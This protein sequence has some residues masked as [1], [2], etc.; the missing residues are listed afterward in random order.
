MGKGAI[1]LPLLDLENFLYA[2]GN[3][4]CN[5]IIDGAD[6]AGVKKSFLYPRLRSFPAS[7]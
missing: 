1:Y 6:V 2:S 4:Q 3:L 7:L 5:I